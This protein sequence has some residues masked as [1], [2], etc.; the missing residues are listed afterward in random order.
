MTHIDMERRLSGRLELQFGATVRGVLR[1]RITGWW[2]N[3][4]GASGACGNCPSWKQG[5]ADEQSYANPR[6]VFSFSSALAGNV[7]VQV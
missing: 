2:K 4:P 6:L 5:S 7:V 3:P 1:F